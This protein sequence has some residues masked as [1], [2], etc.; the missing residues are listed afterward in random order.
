[1]LGGRK[2]TFDARGAAAADEHGV[3]EIYER[4]GRATPT[5][6]ELQAYSGVYASDEAETILTAVVE[7]GNLILKRRPDTK[8]PLTPLYADAFSGPQIGTIIFRRDA[9]GRID[10]LS[11][12]QDRVWDLRF[13][14]R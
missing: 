11:V 2:W 7:N 10:T 5:A 12:V 6:E 8:L 13:Q 1:M 4:V 14:K 3:V 9:A